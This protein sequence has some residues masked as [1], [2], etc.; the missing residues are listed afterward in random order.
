M[1]NY[2]YIKRKAEDLAESIK[3]FDASD[4]FTLNY[5]ETGKFSFTLLCLAAA[6]YGAGHLV[7]KVLK[8]VK[9]NTDKK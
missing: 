5:K 2:D 8:E 6:L 7:N 1:F 3:E 9:D 4:Y